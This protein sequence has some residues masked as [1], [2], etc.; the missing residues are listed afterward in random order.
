MSA[1]AQKK[2]LV[3]VKR[4]SHVRTVSVAVSAI[5]FD[6]TSE[7]ADGLSEEEMDEMTERWI[8][9]YQIETDDQDDCLAEVLDVVTETAGWCVDDVK[10]KVIDA[11]NHKQGFLTPDEL[12]RYYFYTPSQK[13]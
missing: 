13:N 8:G 6:F 1:P 2:K 3:I 7:G 5:T 4:V 9:I 11:K 10:Y 12:H